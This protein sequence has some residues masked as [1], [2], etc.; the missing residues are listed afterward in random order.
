MTRL[1][2]NG[3]AG[4]NSKYHVLTANGELRLTRPLSAESRQTGYRL[5]ISNSK[6]QLRD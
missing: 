4:N 5:A 3:R 6:Q 2:P 1:C